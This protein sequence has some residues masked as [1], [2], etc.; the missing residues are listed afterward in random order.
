MNIELLLAF[1]GVLFFGVLVYFA[2]LYGKKKE[3][4]K[5]RFIR[6]LGFT[7][8]ENS[9][10]L[11]ERI[12][13][14]YERDEDSSEAVLRNVFHKTLLEGEMYIFDVLGNDTERNVVAV[15]SSAL[16]LPHFRIFPKLARD[17][18]IEK[19]M[20]K[21]LVWAISRVE[22]PLVFPE[23]PDFDKQYLVSSSTPTSAYR[24]LDDNLLL[25]FAQIKRCVVQAEGNMFVLSS[26]IEGNDSSSRESL[27][28]R[29]DQAMRVFQI[30]RSAGK[31]DFKF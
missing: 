5:K 30:L 18:A 26:F 11:A 15:L 12:T 25:Q 2:V 13:Q 31:Y 14:F 28:Q 3:E 10:A 23:V 20:N 8:L 6:A 27:R 17:N 22:T 9:A 24:F 7:P 19:W 16:V 21:A 29:V 1:G 4:E